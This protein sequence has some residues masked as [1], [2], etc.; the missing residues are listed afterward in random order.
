L[1]RVLEEADIVTVHVPLLETTHHMFHRGNL[2]GFILINTARGEVVDNRALLKAIDGDQLR[3]C[4]LDVWENEPDISP[5]LLDVV[6]I[7]TPHIA[8]YSLDGKANGTRMIYEAACRHFG[9][10]PVW[11]PALPAPPAIDLA[12]DLRQVVKRM[13]DIT[14]DDVALRANVRDFDKLRAEYPVRREFHTYGF[15]L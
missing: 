10:K 7:G 4:V 8:G 14:A 2:E 5:E 12:G 1:D 9:I 11:K 6:D 3:G 13:Y 15:R